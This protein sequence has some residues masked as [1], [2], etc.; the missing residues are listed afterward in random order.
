MLNV[1]VLVVIL[2]LLGVGIDGAWSDVLQDLR[3]PDKNLGLA[4]NSNTAL[5]GVGILFA[6]VSTADGLV[7]S[8]SQIVA[9]DIYRRTIVPW[10][11]PDL[12]GSQRDDRVLLICRASTIVILFACMGLGWA[13]PDHSITLIVWIGIGGMMAA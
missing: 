2:F 12:T 5:I 4:I 9:N 11:K 8:T 1:A 7:V 10:R 13:M 6:I 3:A